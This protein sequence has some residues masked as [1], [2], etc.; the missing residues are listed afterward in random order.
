MT[1]ETIELVEWLVKAY[2]GGRYFY[3]RQVMSATQYDQLREAVRRQIDRIH[4]EDAVRDMLPPLAEYG[5]T[6]AEWS[7]E[8][9]RSFHSVPDEP[10]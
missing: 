9:G 3:S 5:V 4:F 6:D 2:G 7:G 10:Q 1:E 8:F